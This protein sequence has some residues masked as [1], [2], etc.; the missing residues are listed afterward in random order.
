[1]AYSPTEEPGLAILCLVSDRARGEDELH[2]SLRLMVKVRVD[3]RVWVW[4]RVPIRVRFRVRARVR[5]VT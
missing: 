3:V 5:V 2:Q 1:M 4:V